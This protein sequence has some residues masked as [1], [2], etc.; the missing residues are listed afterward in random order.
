MAVADELAIAGLD[1]AAHGYDAGAAFDGQAF[2][3]VVV[4][5]G[6]L[7]FDADRAAIRRIINYE[8][9][10][11][12]D[13]DGALA[14]VEA[15]EFCSAGAGAID[16]AFEIDAVAL[17]AVGVEEIDAI[18]DARDAVGNGGEVVFAEEFLLEIEGAV[19][20]ANGVHS[21]EGKRGPE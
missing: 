8:V 4:V 21:T 16:E 3:A 14:R 6:V 13:R 18:L 7:S 12:T 20:G 15:E 5:I 2:E 19:I 10:V 9:G 11:A 1:F 17:H